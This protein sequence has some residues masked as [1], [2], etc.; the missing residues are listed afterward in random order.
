MSK[1]IPIKNLYKG[2]EGEWLIAG[3]LFGCGLEA[4]KLLA[5]RGLD[6]MV[7]NHHGSQ[8]P[9][10]INRRPFP[11]F[12][13]VKSYR[14]AERQL[15]HRGGREI[16]EA[17]FKLT[18]KEIELLCDQVAGFLV[19]AIK[20][21]MAPTFVGEHWV[22]AWIDGAHLQELIKRKYLRANR[23][24]DY[25]LA[26]ACTWPE[27]RSL[28]NVTK[29]LE[30]NGVPLSNKQLTILE[31]IV[32][33]EFYSRGTLYISLTRYNDTRRQLHGSNLDLTQLGV[34]QES[35]FKDGWP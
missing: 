26:V 29:C 23:S 10:V 25:E 34:Q 30:N 24:G 7:T 15:S 33:S 12:L 32:P 18:A 17:N 8:E 4:Y 2:F 6:L 22:Y 28:N 13:Q 21:P 35:P 20:L 11:S 9:T 5:D 16:T 1:Q 31:S 3:K 14:A 19:L 27:R